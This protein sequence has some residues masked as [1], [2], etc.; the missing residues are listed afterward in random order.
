M[1][2]GAKW[3]PGIPL[4]V[5]VQMIPSWGGSKCECPTD[6]GVTPSDSMGKD[7]P[8]DDPE[9][10]CASCPP[11]FI[12]DDEGHHCGM[13]CTDYPNM[14]ITPEEARVRDLCVGPGI[15]E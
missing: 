1:S 5:D 4:G 2:D 14:Q 15:G 10:Y 7:L 12:P 9:F 6:F 13:P 3:C 8:T 11:G